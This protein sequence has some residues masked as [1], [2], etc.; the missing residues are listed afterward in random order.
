MGVDW[1]SVGKILRIGTIGTH[2][3]VKNIIIVFEI[4]VFTLE[5]RG[6]TTNQPWSFP[7]RFSLEP[8]WEGEKMSMSSCHGSITDLLHNIAKAWKHH[9]NMYLLRNR[10]LQSCPDMDWI[11]GFSFGQNM[12]SRRIYWYMIESRARPTAGLLVILRVAVARVLTKFDA[13]A[14]SAQAA[15]GPSFGVAPSGQCRNS[16]CSCRWSWQSHPICGS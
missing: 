9:I 4:N 2:W 13:S 12:H 16:S 3:L 5:T 8:V 14:V 15:D 10:C 7:C 11:C 1:A 6:S